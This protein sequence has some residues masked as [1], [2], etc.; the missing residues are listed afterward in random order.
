M[1]ESPD[2]LVVGAGVIGTSVAFHLAKA[3]AKV[4]LLDKRSPGSGTSRASFGAIV[5]L[6]NGPDD[7]FR[8]S[9]L[10]IEAYKLLEEEL[11][12]DAG[13]GEG[14]SVRWPETG[15]EGTAAVTLRIEEM[16]RLGYPYQVITAAE[17][18]EIEPHVTVGGEVG[19]ILFLPEERWADGDLLSRAFARKAA[20]HGASIAA[21]C[22]VQKLIVRTGAVVGVSTSDG[23]LFADHVVVAAGTSSVDLLRPLGIELPLRTRTAVTGVTGS[24]PNLISHMLYIGDYHIRPM[25]SQG[26]MIEWG[27]L[28]SY[29]D[30]NTDLSTTP[31]WAAFFVS[32]AR[33]NIPELRGISI[34]EVRGA[35]NP[36]PGDG[37]PVVGPL[38]GTKGVSVVVTQSGVTLA[39]II[40]K[41]VAQEIMSDQPSEILEP[42]RLD[43]FL[44][45]G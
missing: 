23:E 8:L 4:T 20:S 11:G 36:V 39:A 22:A 45:S 42:Y 41:S 34:Q 30:E 28:N 14:G 12:P 16:E 21:S 33:P 32:K 38:T 24:V 44:S 37:L 31:E 7:Y 27:E 3:G 29:V 40:G 19:P 2:V 35:P 6:W 15:P 25:T 26:L 10:S 17:A 43:R 13:L 9:Q 5:G 1:R 18:S